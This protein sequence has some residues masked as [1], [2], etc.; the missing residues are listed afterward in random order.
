MTTLTDTLPEAPKSMNT[1]REWDGL[2]LESRTEYGHAARR[3]RGNYAGAKIHRLRTEYI[4]GIIP[5]TPIALGT[6][7]ARFQKTGKPVLFSARPA[8]GCT[9]GQMAG[10]PIAELAAEHVNCAKC[11]TKG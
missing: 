8:C 7:G 6:L 9:Q 4:V 10:M 2:I 5:G 3:N 1:Q 11:I